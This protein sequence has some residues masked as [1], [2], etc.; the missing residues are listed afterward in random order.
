ML[1]L[2]HAALKLCMQTAA[3]SHADMMLELT[4]LQGRWSPSKNTLGA[5][6]GLLN[7]VFNLK[8]KHVLYFM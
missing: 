4:V 7:R 6:L 2:L 1:P 5:I 8:R 3:L